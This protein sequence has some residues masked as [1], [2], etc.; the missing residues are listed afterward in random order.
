MLEVLRQDYVVTARAKGL[1]PR[2]V[3]GRHALRNALIP[4]VTFIGIQFGGLLGGAVITETVFARQGI[5]QL[6]VS[7]IQKR[8]MPLIE[9][10]VI[11]VGMVTVLANLIVDLLY[12]VLDPR[13]R[14]S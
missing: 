2:L 4:V 8:D 9:G 10:T 3:I 14:V 6:A 7:A 11:F 1:S 12:A 5:G 13:I